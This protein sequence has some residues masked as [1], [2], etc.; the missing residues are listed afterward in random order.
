MKCK[1][2]WKRQTEERISSLKALCEYKNWAP[3]KK[4]LNCELK[5]FVTPYYASL[6]EKADYS[7]PIFAM[8]VPSPEEAVSENDSCDPLEEEKFMPVPG[9]IRRYPDRAVY[10]ATLNCASRCRHCTRRWQIIKNACSSWHESLPKVL[11]YL[12]NHPE[13]EEIIVSG[14][15]PL[16]LEDDEIAEI[17]SAF[18]KQGVK[19]LR[20]GTRVPVTCPMRITEELCLKLKPFSPIWIQTH[21]N[22]PREVTA[23]AKEALSKLADSGFPINN[24]TVLLK[25]VNDNTGTLEKL[26]RLL[27]QNRVRP[28]YLF[29]CDKIP[30]TEHFWTSLE[31]GL[32]IMQELR[33][34]LSGIAVPTFIVDRPAL[35]GKVP[36]SYAT[37]KDDCLVFP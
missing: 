36:L 10:T 35:N 26:F 23:E 3:P 1:E 18:K 22:H 24:Q 13:I 33:A 9:L 19:V 14:G 8:S 2:D 28:Y 21:F 12:K 29:Q 37:A 6:M 17:V 32:K 7:D 15:D 4:V 34:R 31:T 5:M 20:L 11:D 27:I 25:G 30:G 16:T